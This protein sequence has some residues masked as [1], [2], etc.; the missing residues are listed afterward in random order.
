MCA[1]VC[2]FHVRGDRGIYICFTF[3]LFVEGGGRVC[4]FRLKEGG[5]YVRVCVFVMV[6]GNLCMSL[7]DCH[8]VCMCTCVCFS[9]WDGWGCLYTCAVSL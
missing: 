6:G 4:V 2:V 7:C 8:W 1:R 3:F 9:R 5:L